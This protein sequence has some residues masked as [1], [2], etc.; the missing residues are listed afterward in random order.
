VGRP[1]RRSNVPLCPRTQQQQQPKLI[2]LF[3][4]AWI[5]WIDSF[6]IYDI[7]GDGYIDRYAHDS[8]AVL[9]VSSPLLSPSLFLPGPHRNELHQLLKAALSENMLDLTD[10]QIAT[11]VDD[12]FAQVDS[13]GSTITP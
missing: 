10:E 13:N 8:S 2:T 1:T 7:D 9:E 3:L 5:V 6:R 11:L 12:T 4:N